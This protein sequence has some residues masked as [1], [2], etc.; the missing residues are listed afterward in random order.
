MVVHLPELFIVI[1]YYTML[2]LEQTNLV[3]STMRIDG[4]DYLETV[5]C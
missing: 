4:C 3:Y 5:R 1:H 2:R